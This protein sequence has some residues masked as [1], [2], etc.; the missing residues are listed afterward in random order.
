MTEEKRMAIDPSFEIIEP[1]EAVIHRPR[2]RP[3]RNWKPLLD[4]LIE[5]STVFLS[6]QELTD[7]DVKY[8]TLAFYRR[9]EGELLRQSREI[10][11]MVAG[12]VLWLEI[13]ED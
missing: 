5:G 8:L 12:R 10:R 2:R 4:V 11:D 9:G 7:A 3:R 13:E 6:D 1:R